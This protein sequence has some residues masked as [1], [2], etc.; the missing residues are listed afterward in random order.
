MQASS[1]S[2]L[3]ALPDRHLRRS[4]RSSLAFH[5]SSLLAA[6]ALAACGNHEAADAP[7]ARAPLLVHKPGDP[8]EVTAKQK[9][10]LTI[11]PAAASADA[12]VINAPGRVAFRSQAQ[13]AVGAIAAGRISAVLVR[14]GESVKA[15]AALVVIDS[16]DASAARSTLD[17]SATRLANAEAVH[18]RT[19]TMMEKGVGIEVERLEAETKLKEARAEHARA[20]ESVELLGDGKG[21]RVTVRAP[22]AGIV[23]NIRA[24]VGATVAPGGDPLL[25]LGDPSR[26]Q[27][28]AHVTESDLARISVGEAAEVGLPSIGARLSARIETLNPRV[29]PESRRAQVYLGLAAPAANLREGMLAQVSMLAAAESGVRLPVAAVLIKD[30]KQRVVYVELPD[31]KFEPRE[32]QT[33]RVRDG[34]VAILKGI[35]PGERVVV[36]GALL[37]DTQAEQ[38]L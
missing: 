18:R 24:A 36:R 34:R 13:Y 37:L 1:S 20:R 10:F 35:A 27:I 21:L 32:V 4:L 7:K 29:D 2:R 11:E 33:G 26:L 5:L 12:E 17:Q 31:G 6:L 25:E 23:T 38:Q 3:P 9:Q 28:V 19:V 8:A 16:G 14:N 15:G 22:A 30:G